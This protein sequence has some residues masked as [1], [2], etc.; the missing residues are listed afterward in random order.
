MEFLLGWLAA[1]V[2]GTAAWLWLLFLGIIVFLLVFDLG[3]L[4]RGAREIGARESLALSAGYISVAALFGAWVWWQLGAASGMLYFTGFL[5]EKS[6]ALDN[7]FVISVIFGYFA[8]PRLYQHRV[9]FWGVLGVV[10]LRGLLIGGGAALVQSFDWVLYIFAALLLATGLKMLVLADAKPDIAANPLLRLLRRG[11]RVTPELHGDRFLVRRPDAAGRKRFHATPLLLALVL[12]EVADLVF[13]VDSVPAILAITTDPFI[14][15]TS[16]IFAILGL[17]ALYFAVA[18][19]AERFHYLKY[20]LAA[21]LIAV[22][23]K[24]VYGGL[25]GKVEPLLSLA[26]TATLIGGGIVASLIKTWP[27]KEE[28]KG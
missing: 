24:I 23:G 14:V 22:A 15:Y 27:M 13:A 5:I 28:A 12:I 16:N 3:V 19:M 1:P 7:V 21:V 4:H 17:R 8:V 2:F 18:A 9:L 6:L 25:Y 11:L 10:V 20:A 26:V